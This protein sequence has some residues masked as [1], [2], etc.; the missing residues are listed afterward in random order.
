M[1]KAKSRKD[2]VDQWHYHV[3]EMFTIA[4]DTDLET[5]IEIQET[6]IKLKKLIV[7]VGDDLVDDGMLTY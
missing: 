7:K 5:G 4:H 3:Q 6:L 2:Y 1:A